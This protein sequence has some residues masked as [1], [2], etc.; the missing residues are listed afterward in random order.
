MAK[1]MQVKFDKYCSEYNILLSCAAVLDPRFK[2][3]RVEYCFAKL[4]GEH[5]LVR[6]FH[7]LEL[8]CLIYLTSIKE[9]HMAHLLLLLPQLSSRKTNISNSVSCSGDQMNEMMEYKMFSSKKRKV[10]SEKSELELYLE[11]KNSDVMEKCDV[12][13]YW[14]KSSVRYPNLACMARDILTIPISTV[15][16]ESAFSMSKQ[17]INPWRASLGEETIEVLACYEDWLRAKGFTL[18]L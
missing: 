18:G 15:P 8:H 13:A 17:L 2:L 3:E 1:D 16:S 9:L 5:I 14:N 6:W 10:D 11:E 12:L 7:V 4:Y